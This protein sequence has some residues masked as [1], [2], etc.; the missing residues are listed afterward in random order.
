MLC[1]FYF[2]LDPETSNLFCYMPFRCHLVIVNTPFHASE[3]GLHHFGDLPEQTFLPERKSP[4]HS[5]LLTCE[6][7]CS[8]A[9]HL[10]SVWRVSKYRSLAAK[11][12]PLICGNALSCRT[13]DGPLPSTQRGM[14]GGQA[15]LAQVC[16][17]FAPSIHITCRKPRC[18]L[19]Q[20][21]MWS[22]P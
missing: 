4:I 10:L 12:P 17:Q 1:H 7:G 3:G 14:A 8:S 15:R 16:P 18:L 20:F 22:R 11:Y 2:A 9:L 5:D 21:K 13:F 6:Y 19:T